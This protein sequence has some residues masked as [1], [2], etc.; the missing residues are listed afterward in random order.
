MYFYLREV[1]ENTLIPEL[2]EIHIWGRK[3][4]VRIPDPT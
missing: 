1:N 3:A 4:S 2:E